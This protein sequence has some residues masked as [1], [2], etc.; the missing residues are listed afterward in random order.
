[1]RF[2][3]VTPDEAENAADTA[4]AAWRPWLV[5]LRVVGERPA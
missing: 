3:V 5:R 4:D 2:R 1:V